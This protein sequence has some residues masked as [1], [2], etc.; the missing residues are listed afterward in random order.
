MR[1]HIDHDRGDPVARLH[2]VEGALPGLP[3][4]QGSGN[5][6]SV[7]ALLGDTPYPR[8]PHGSEL[9]PGRSLPPSFLLSFLQPA[10]GSIPGDTPGTSLPKH[11]PRSTL[12]TT[13]GITQDHPRSTQRTIQ[14]HPDDCLGII[15][16]TT[17]ITILGAPQR[18][19][20]WPPQGHPK[21]TPRTISVTIPGAP[22]EQSQSPPQDPPDSPDRGVVEVGL[23]VAAQPIVDHL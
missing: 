14:D 7:W 2:S 1:T 9:L 18:L 21:Y 13:L 19:S 6:Q 12:G 4:K 5:G 23:V 11:H 10:P 16:E 15:P 17:L 8:G 3:Q 22:I 20:W